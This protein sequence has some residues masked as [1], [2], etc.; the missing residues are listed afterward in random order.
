MRK[1][2]V[3]LATVASMG[4]GAAVTTAILP[5]PAIAQT[6]TPSQRATPDD[7]ATPSTPRRA[8]H[9]QGSSGSGS[10]TPS[11]EGTPTSPD[12]SV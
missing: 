9:H 4:V 3:A 5:G 2:V 11:T 10:S 1:F 7:N 8:C 6:P 12:T